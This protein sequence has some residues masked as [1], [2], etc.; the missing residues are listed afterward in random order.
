[1]RRVLLGAALMLVL[2]LLSAAVAM[3]LGLLPVSADGSH[4]R[5]EAGVMPVVL[6]ASVARRASGEKNPFPV[7]ED[8][9]KTGIL[10]YKQMC[11]TC[12]G[13]VRTGPTELGQSFY[14]PAPSLSGTAPQYTDS[15]LFWI[16]KHG[17][18]NTGMPA[19]GP[20]LSDKE[21]WQL[22]AILKQPDSRL[23]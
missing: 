5:F 13:T 6:H 15:E 20:M 2:L 8:N 12:H 22:V 21:I 9:L 18:R 11:A 10:T 3:R 23:K 14:P 1:M 7:T 4:S 17:I 19:W 16:I